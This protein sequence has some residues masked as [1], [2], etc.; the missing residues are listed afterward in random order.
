MRG[1]PIFRGD[2]FS[3]LLEALNNHGVKRS[4]SLDHR[5]KVVRYNLNR[6]DGIPHRLPS[7]GWAAMT[8][9]GQSDQYDPKRNPN[10]SHERP[11]FTNAPFWT[12]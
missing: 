1:S 8:Q 12:T 10:P 3:F 11:P 6:D 2:Q 7:Y 5:M 4:V 9:P